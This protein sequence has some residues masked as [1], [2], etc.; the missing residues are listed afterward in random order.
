MLGVFALDT[1]D[2]LWI[3]K[4]YGPRKRPTEGGIICKPLCQ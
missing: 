3:S 2:N 4:S 1:H